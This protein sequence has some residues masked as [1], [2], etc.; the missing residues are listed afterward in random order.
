[1]LFDERPK[2]NR[3]DLYDTEE[4]LK[5]LTSA[6]EMGAPLVT[7]IGLRRAG[8]TSLLLTALNSVAQPSLILD[9]RTLAG[10]PYI[11]KRDLFQE[12]ERAINGF[13]KKH[14][15]KG[16]RL[17][18]WLARVKG[19]E[20]S[21]TGITLSWGGKQPLD[22]SALFEELNSWAGN[23][24]TTLVIAFDEAQELKKV[25]GVNMEKIIAHI[26][27]YNRNL[28]VVLT[29]SAVGLLYDFIGCQD[30]KAPLYGRVIT[31]IRLQRLSAEKSRDF[32][33]CG[34]KQA[35]VDIDEQIIKAALEKLDGVIGWL[36]LFGETSVANGSM[37]N[38]MIN[39]AIEQGKLLAR[40]EFE[41][42]LKGREVAQQR[43]MA[44]TRHLASVSTSSWSVI[45]RAVE[46]TEGKTVDDRNITDLIQNLVKAGFV[47]K[48]NEAYRLTDQMLAESLK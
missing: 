18:R 47:E 42:F 8:K 4:E 5:S 28:S 23:E 2:N 1:L 16:R 39:Q 27:D 43:Y 9:M 22:V 33:L 45:K 41:N 6:L 19:V 20:I 3:K 36:N 21:K 26:Y 14:L 48:E 35:K 17:L 30:P 32:L 44:I 13:Y 29:G 38:K 11:S 10:K 37:S 34:F 31:E 25:A 15:G 40:Q 12:I 46:A 7:I 24:K